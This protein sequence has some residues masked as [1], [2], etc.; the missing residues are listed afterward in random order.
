MWVGII[1]P[2]EWRHRSKSAESKIEES[3]RTSMD[4]GGKIG[5]R[6]PIISVSKR[7]PGR[8]LRVL[9]GEIGDRMFGRSMKLLSG[10]SRDTLQYL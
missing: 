5:H 6:S 1:G 3:R 2:V 9:E 8:G 4:I 7:C 10:G